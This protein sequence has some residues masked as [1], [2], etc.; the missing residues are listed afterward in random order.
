MLSLERG[1]IKGR[2]DNGRYVGRQVIVWDWTAIR[3]IGQDVLHW[4]W[5]ELVRPKPL[6]QGD[7]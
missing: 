3:L 7:L 4:D 2:V 5:L 6:G 1:F